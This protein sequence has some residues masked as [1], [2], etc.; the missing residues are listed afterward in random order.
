MV[1]RMRNLKNRIQ[2]SLMFLFILSGFL[3]VARFSYAAKARNIDYM[4]RDQELVNTEKNYSIPYVL[5]ES[6]CSNFL[7]E[8]NTKISRCY[9]CQ[10]LKTQCSDCCIN[11]TPLNA[12]KTKCKDLTDSAQ[13]PIFQPISSTDPRKE[14]SDVKDCPVPPNADPGLTD[15]TYT[16]FKNYCSDSSLVT[17]IPGCQAKGCPDS[18]GAPKQGSHKCEGPDAGGVFICNTDTINKLEKPGCLPVTG[19]LVTDCD[20]LHSKYIIT[21]IPDKDCPASYYHCWKYKLT[22]KLKGCISDCKTKADLQ[23]KSAKDLDCC[24]RDSNICES[25]P[26]SIVG[27][28]SERPGYQNN[29]TNDDAC[30]QRVNWLEC[31]LDA[32]T[33]PSFCCDN[34]TTDDCIEFSQ[35]RDETINNMITGTNFGCFGDISKSGDAF[36]YEFVAKSNEK[37]M[38]IWQVQASPEYFYCGSSSACTSDQ[39]ASALAMTSLPSTGTAPNTYFYTLVKIFDM[40]D[41]NQEVYPYPY[42]DTVMNQ[43]SFTAA[44]SMFAAIATDKDNATEP[45]SIFKQGH[46]YKIKLY[47]LIAPLSNYVLQS[48]ISHLQFVVL[49][50]RE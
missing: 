14:C 44:F 10:L 27:L 6:D 29:C 25:S 2:I 26:G 30:L 12:R 34:L 17:G 50:V 9:D 49:R 42:A 18:S 48:K 8:L 31:Q 38:V 22:D 24:K 28:N 20:T 15:L 23:E 3:F 32:D 33:I 37:L 40:S 43:K 5:R 45:K 39:E 41:K 4:P 36:T 16:N 35:L 13:N 19:S 21:K 46:K 47:Y 1:E 7:L 11:K